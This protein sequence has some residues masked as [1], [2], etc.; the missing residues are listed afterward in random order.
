MIKYVV[1]AL[2][3]FA[4]GSAQAADVF[5]KMFPVPGV[6]TKILHLTD[7]HSMGCSA[8]EYLRVAK[9]HDSNKGDV[10]GVICWISNLDRPGVTVL[11]RDTGEKLYVPDP[12]TIEGNP[13]ALEYLMNQLE[14]ERKIR[15][16]DK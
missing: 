15:I 16:T 4:C 3:M 9:L 5:F 14:K 1:W 6:G 8:K 7:A 13:A 12:E 2:F 10:T 11:F